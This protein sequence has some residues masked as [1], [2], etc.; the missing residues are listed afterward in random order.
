MARIFAFRHLDERLQE[1]AVD[2][3]QRIAVNV[4]V[5]A[6]Q[7]VGACDEPGDGAEFLLLIKQLP[8]IFRLHA[9][10]F[11]RTPVGPPQQLDRSA[12]R[13]VAH[14]PENRVHPGMGPV[15]RAEQMP[16]PAQSLS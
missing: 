14:A 7:R 4:F 10:L 6:M 9:K 15:G 11:E 16:A 2:F 8:R 12:E 5:A 3:F 1:Q 13:D